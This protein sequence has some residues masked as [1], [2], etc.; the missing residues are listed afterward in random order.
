[1]AEG[2]VDIG[3]LDSTS[4]EPDAIDELVECESSVVV[5]DRVGMCSIC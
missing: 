3:R 5:T 4:N 2:T 1:M